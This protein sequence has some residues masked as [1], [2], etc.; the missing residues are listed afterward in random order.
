MASAPSYDLWDNP[1]GTDGFEFVEY[2]AQRPEQLAQL[3]EQLGFVAVARHRSGGRST[4][5]REPA[6]AADADR[7]VDYLAVGPVHATPTKP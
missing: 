6:D 4:P 7:D 3:F 2:T 5:A 1:L